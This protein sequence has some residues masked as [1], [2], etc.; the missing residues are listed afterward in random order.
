MEN[1]RSAASSVPGTPPNSD[2]SAQ[3]SRPSTGGSAKAGTLLQQL[4][5]AP[6]Y[7]FIIV[8][9]NRLLIIQKR[10]GIWC[11]QRV[12]QVLFLLLLRANTTSGYT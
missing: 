2:S 5:S 9:P 8:S 7:K 10:L 1:P 3:S 12:L 6:V 11:A 4:P